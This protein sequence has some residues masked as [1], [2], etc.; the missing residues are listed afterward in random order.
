MSRSL[1]D[2]SLRPYVSSQPELVKRK[3]DGRDKVLVLGSDGIWD[4]V[5][6]QEAVEIAGRHGDPN[7]AAR[8]LTGLARRRW[9]AETEGLVSDDITAVVVRLGSDS[10]ASTPA[11]HRNSH[12]GREARWANSSGDLDSIAGLTNRSERTSRAPA[13]SMQSMDRR[14]APST[15]LPPTVTSPSEASRHRHGS[16]HA[17]RSRSEAAM[18]YS[19]RHGHGGR[20]DTTLPN[21]AQ[22]KCPELLP[23]AGRRSGPARPQ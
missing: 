19:R 11:K 21:A 6:S 18:G 1:G 22:M 9:N 13:S 8:E 3:L 4:H 14:V 17:S 5:S 16:G 7:Q 20:L 23:P 12:R 10:R 15:Y 2:L